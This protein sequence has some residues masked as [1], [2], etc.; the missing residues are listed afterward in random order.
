MNCLLSA[1]A[2][3]VECLGVLVWSHGGSWLDLSGRLN[4]PKVQTA[5]NTFRGS[6]HFNDMLLQKP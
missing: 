1:R 3:Y 6:G 5:R 4:K 2:L